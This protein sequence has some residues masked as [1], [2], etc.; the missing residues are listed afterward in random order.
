MSGRSFS[1]IA[2]WTVFTCI[3]NGAVPTTTGS[4]TWHQ[5]RLSEPPEPRTDEENETV[6]MREAAARPVVWQSEAADVR[7]DR[8]T[9]IRILGI[10]DFHGHLSAGQRVEGRPVGGAAVLASNLNRAAP[11][12]IVH[13]GDHV[14]ASPP[15]SSFFQ[16]EPS[17]A[18]FNLLG[19]RHCSFE[20]R[21][22]ARCNLV[23][24]PGNHEFDEGTKELLRLIEGGNHPT[25]PFFDADYRGTTFPYVSS[26]VID[27]VSGRTI[28]PPYVIKE[29]GGVRLAFIGATLKETPSIVPPTGIADLR[30]LDEASSMNAVIRRLQEEE[31]IHTFV[32]LIHQGGKQ[33][34]YQ[35]MTLPDGAVD[36]QEL[37]DIVWKLDDDVDVVVSGHSHSFTNALLKNRH[38][39]EILVTQAFS[40]GTAYADIQVAIDRETGAVMEKRAAIVT[41]FADEGPG[42]TPDPQAARLVAQA[43]AAAAPRAQRR[44][45]A[46]AKPISRVENEAGESA[47]GDL[48]A[49]AQRAAL[50][51]DF[52]FMNPGG[53]RTDLPAGPLTYRDLF[54]VHPFGNNLVSMSLTGQEIYDLLNQQ[55]VGQTRPRI[56]KISGLTYTWDSRRPIGDRIVDISRNGTPLDR[57][58]QYSVTVNDFLAEGGDNFLLLKRGHHRKGGPVDVD[59]L[60]AHV[61]SLP[62]PFDPPA[63]DRISRLP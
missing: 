12:F 25:G 48:I 50:G 15:E 47:L 63:Q 36:G 4:S 26:N 39:K 29:A 14:G 59:A 27:H 57:E 32:V 54:A 38:G 33:P 55:W 61:A 11:T 24:T 20:N 28:L 46:A 56:L 31:G 9:Q 49:D 52:A 8:F 35:G 7:P 43:E 58:S 6:A 5:V 44:I 13:A 37:A 51:T 23:G 2:L 34:A 62:Q 18:F 30:F 10:N 3:L 16:D 22:D 41:A 17:I 53:I 40:Y 45:A 42:L 1:V 19:N 21:M 60:I